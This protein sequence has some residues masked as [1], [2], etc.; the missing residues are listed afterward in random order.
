MT[1]AKVIEL[2][3][4]EGYAADVMP[5]NG[6]VFIAADCPRAYEAAMKHCERVITLDLSEFVKMDGG[7]TCLSL[8]Y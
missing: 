7:L 3:A 8:R 4:E 6:S 5:V 2:P 1:W